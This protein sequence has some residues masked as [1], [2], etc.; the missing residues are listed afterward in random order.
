MDITAFSEPINRLLKD[1]EKEVLQFIDNRLIEYQVDEYQRNSYVK[2]I[3]HRTTPIHIDKVYQSL[4]LYEQGTYGDNYETIR[5]NTDNVETLFKNRKYITVIGS[6]G[7]GKSMLVKK[8][9]L[10]A[11]REQE[12]I[13]IKV[14]L[15]YLNEF[16]GD[17]KMYILEEKF[18]FEKL[19]V[20]DKRANKLLESGKFIFF[21]DGYDEIKS[22]K[23]FRITKQINDFVGRYNKNLFLLT[24]RP[25]TD[26]ELFPL[27]HNLHVCGLTD[28]E[29][30]QFIDKQ[31]PQNQKEL[32]DKI[33]E[34]IQKKE[35]RTYGSFLENPLLLSLFILS[36]QSY[37]EIPQY[38]STFYRQVFDALFSL[39][40][41]M[42]KLAFVREKISGLSKEQFEKVLEIFSFTTYLNELYLFKKHVIINIFEH[43]KENK[44]DL[45]FDNEKL[46]EDLTIAL[47]IFTIEGLDYSF[48][49][50]SLQEYFAAKYISELSINN[51]KAIYSKIS[52]RIINKSNHDLFNFCTILKEVDRKDYIDFLASPC[53]YYYGKKFS[54]EKL[55][56]LDENELFRLFCLEFFAIHLF[57]WQEVDF[58]EYDEEETKL[59]KE[60]ELLFESSKQGKITK[61]EHNEIFC[62]LMLNKVR[63]YMIKVSDYITTKEQELLDNLEKSNYGDTNIINNIL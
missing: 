43:I 12:R 55:L 20:D 24:S 19:S 21:L 59:R 51:K 22:L 42:S 3:I 1:I 34:A 45:K 62:N 40:D 47:A 54:S 14:E 18:K 5:I 30:G 53:L 10:D 35:N 17:L 29:V 50:R 36:F 52:K 23:K 28:G 38:R 31:I 13:P 9:F 58:Q 4:F 56:N 26:I 44:E 46:L 27:F 57:V 41:S 60:L 33:K 48:P 11:V 15:R 6:A 39:H 16:E 49:H 25:F 2:T 61:D 37:A 63:P 8:L 7:S 32:A